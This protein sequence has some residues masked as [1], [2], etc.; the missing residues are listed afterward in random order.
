MGL[1]IGDLEIFKSLL[2]TLATSAPFGAWN[3]FHMSTLLFIVS[4][5]VALLGRIKLNDFVSAYGEGAKKMSKSITLFV[6][7]YMVMIAAYMSPFVPT[8]T[9]LLF[10]GVSKFNP[11]LVSLAAFIAVS[12]A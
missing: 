2:G 1:K 8:I 6:L 10:S 3:L 5:V 4:I 11:F 12:S 7:V 9:N